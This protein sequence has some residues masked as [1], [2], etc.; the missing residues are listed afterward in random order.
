VDHFGPDGGKFNPERWLKSVDDPVEKETVGLPHLSFGAGS[1]ACSGQFIASRLLYAALVRLLSSYKIVAS[2]DNPPNTDY[3][4]YNQFKSALVA[5]PRDFK[6][7]L[8]PRDDAMTTECL[9]AA[10]ART[11]DHY[12]E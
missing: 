7:K 1:R 10:E 4:D 5:I 8:I 12:K 2:E 11:K 6:V 9:G 3:V